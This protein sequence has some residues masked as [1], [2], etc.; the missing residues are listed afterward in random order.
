MCVCVCA[1]VVS[2]CLVG[3]AVNE[4]VLKL[5]RGVSL[6]FFFIFWLFCSLFENI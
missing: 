1:A 3:S 6:G 5:F 4:N 2:L